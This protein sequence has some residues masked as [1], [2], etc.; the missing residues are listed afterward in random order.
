MAKT[1]HPVHTQV[2]FP[3][4]DSRYIVDKVFSDFFL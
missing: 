3:Q 2:V 4:K 1:E